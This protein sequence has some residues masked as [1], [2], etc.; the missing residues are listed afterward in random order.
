MMRNKLR[1]MKKHLAEFMRIGDRPLPDASVIDRMKR[2]YDLI[3]EAT[4]K[5]R[6]FEDDLGGLVAMPDFEHAVDQLP[7][8]V[9]EKLEPHLSRRL[10]EVAWFWRDEG[11]YEVRIP[12]PKRLISEQ[13]K[14]ALAYE[15]IKMRER[16]ARISE[17]Y[18]KVIEA[19][20]DLK[21]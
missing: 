2:E 17:A 20:G 15:A 14:N 13:E 11:E 3:Q 21:I 8:S 6:A 18:A 9:A 1:D 7:T 16:L 5:F 19:C 4:E 12:N 10:G